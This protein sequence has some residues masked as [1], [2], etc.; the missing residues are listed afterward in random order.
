MPYRQKARDGRSSPLHKQYFF[1]KNTA[2]FLHS[3]S[4]LKIQS[5][6]DS[7]IPAN[8]IKNNIKPKTAIKL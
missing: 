2:Y 7:F 6:R 4:R 1:P 8:S 5:A 3:V